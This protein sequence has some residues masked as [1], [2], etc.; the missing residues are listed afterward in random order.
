MKN[1][2]S[3][4]TKY[5]KNGQ[6]GKKSSGNESIKEE[7]C[8]TFVEKSL[9]SACERGFLFIFACYSDRVTFLVPEQLYTHPCVMS[10]C[11]PFCVSLV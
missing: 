7:N 11:P 9:N 1:P 3:Y 6:M 8:F 2:K 4:G 5:L 10:V